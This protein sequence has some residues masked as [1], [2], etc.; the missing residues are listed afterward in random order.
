MGR[1]T[2]IFGLKRGI[3]LPVISTLVLI[4]VW[5]AI[6]SF[7]SE[8]LFPDP[9]ETF[10]AIE[11]F[12]GMGIVHQVVKETIFHILSA[13]ALTIVI[14]TLLGV[15]I[16]RF[17]PVEQFAKTYIPILQTVPGLIVIAFALIFFGIG[18]T[19]IIFVTFLA[20]LPY[21]V[22]SVWQG[23]KSVDAD[24][25]EMAWSF[26]SSKWEV[27]RYIVFPGI[28]SYIISGSRIVLGIAWHVAL[29]AEYMMGKSGFGY[30]INIA[31][32]MYDTPGVFAWGV[33]VVLLMILME[34]GLVRPVEE[35]LLSR[36]K[37]TELA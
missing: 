36:W 21:M 24:L 19:G 5:F 3:T 8:T 17:W 28:F 22:V 29:F 26:R 12:A 31:I 30:R 9:Y 34:F 18:D 27:M 20:T 33:L 4:S 13:V 14:G 10:R 25:V 35:R 16:G 32:R 37:R 1:L 11:T 6:G 15:I 2:K 7:Y 23:A